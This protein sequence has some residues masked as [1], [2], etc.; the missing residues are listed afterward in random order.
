MYFTTLFLSIF[1][2]V[3]QA[4]KGTFRDSVFKPFAHDTLL[5]AEDVETGAPLRALDDV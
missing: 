2:L 4:G 5:Q 3:Y 1:Y